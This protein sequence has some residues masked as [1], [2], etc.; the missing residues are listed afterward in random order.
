MPRKRPYT[1]I[2]YLSK[3]K[4]SIDNLSIGKKNSFA[5]VTSWSKKFKEEISLVQQYKNELKK[6]DD[7]YKDK[8]LL[9]KRMDKTDLNILKNKN[10]FLENKNKTLINEIKSFRNIN[11]SLKEK[12]DEVNL[13]SICYENKINILCSPCNHI[14]ICEKCHKGVGSKCP[15]CREDVKKFIKVYI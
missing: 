8:Y 14:C 7:V 3:K 5:N 2:G 1:S 10:R 11:N 15:M 13:C 12:I 4:V 6:L 9:E